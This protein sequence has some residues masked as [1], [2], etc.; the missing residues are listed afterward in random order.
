MAASA[1]KSKKVKAEKVELPE[2]QDVPVRSERKK[3]PSVI[4]RVPNLTSHSVVS[5]CA[6]KTG[7]RGF[8][9][10]LNPPPHAVV[11]WREVMTGIEAVQFLNGIKRR[12][13]KNKLEALTLPAKK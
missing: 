5:V 6:Y 12:N 9:F 4:D 2:V 3:L 7:I 10:T 13:R 8:R 11:V 1:K